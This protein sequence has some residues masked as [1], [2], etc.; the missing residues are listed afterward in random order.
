MCGVCTRRV[1]S[2]SVDARTIKALTV[3]VRLVLTDRTV[4]SPAR[5]AGKGKKCLVGCGRR[6]GGGRVVLARQTALNSSR[7]EGATKI[8]E[9]KQYKRH[10][11]SRLVCARRS[12]VSTQWR[13]SWKEKFTSHKPTRGRGN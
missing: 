9:R 3:H 6:A 11:A 1:A 13:F 5:G 4:E 7:G 2:L 10:P 12:G 8:R